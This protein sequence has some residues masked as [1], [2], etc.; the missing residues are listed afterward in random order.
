MA[1]TAGTTDPL[2]IRELFAHPRRFTFFQAV[3]LLEAYTECAQLGTE[4]SPRGETVRFRADASLSFPVGEVQDICSPEDDD[5]D[6]K[7]RYQLTGTFLG[8]Y[9]PS[10]PMPAF[11][12]ELLIKE[13]GAGTDEDRARLREFLDIFD[14]RMF[15]FCYRALSKYRYHLLFEPGGKDPTSQYMLSLIGRGTEG[16]PD[17]R[18][19]DAIRTIRYSG[20]MTQQPKSCA[21]LEG[22]LRD[23][24][25]GIDVSIEQCVGR[26]LHVEDYNDLGVRFCALG[27]DMIIGSRKY[28][29]NGKFRIT[30]GPVKFEDYMQFLP[31][32]KKTSELHELVRLYLLDELEFDVE[33]W[34][35]AEEVPTTQ[36]GGNDPA[37]MLG[38]TTWLGEERRENRSVVF[39]AA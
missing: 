12:T 4:I 6:A 14:H 16:M 38:W 8:L 36:L 37:P 23:F 34:L 7:T 30:L 22:I 18:P 21:G 26:W 32:R 10:S 27:E 11:Y 20:L 1:E 5:E 2:V 19:V 39:R 33:I 29:R 3:R 9:G 31:G 17:N 13:E 24:F 35:L 25:Q 15:S 28:D